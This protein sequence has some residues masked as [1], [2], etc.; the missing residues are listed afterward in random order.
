[1]AET[2]LLQAIELFKKNFG[3]EHPN[4]AI[5]CNNLGSVY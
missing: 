5:L 2:H 1:M 3:E 4:L